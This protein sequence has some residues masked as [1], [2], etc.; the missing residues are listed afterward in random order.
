VVTRVADH[1]GQGAV[2]AGRGRRGLDGTEAILTLHAVIS[3]GDF[4]EYWRFHLAREHR[5]LYPGT[6]QGQYALGA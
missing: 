5:R 2:L 4:E 3:N 1:S 6:T